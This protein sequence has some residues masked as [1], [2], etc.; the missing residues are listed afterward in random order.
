[1]HAQ[2]LYQANEVKQK[3]EMLNVVLAINS[4]WLNDLFS[5]FKKVKT[6]IKQERQQVHTGVG[7]TSGLLPRYGRSGSV[8][9]SDETW[10]L[11]VARTYVNNSWT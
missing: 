5:A 1:M 6:S 4:I 9:V 2:K 10:S 7:I 3:P 8:M 11:F